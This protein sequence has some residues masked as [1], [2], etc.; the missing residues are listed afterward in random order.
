MDDEQLVIELSFALSDAMEKIEELEVECSRRRQ[1]VKNGDPQ[2]NNMI[3]MKLS[4]RLV[5]LEYITEQQR[6]NVLTTPRLLIQNKQCPVQHPDNKKFYSKLSQLSQFLSMEY[7][8]IMDDQPAILN[9]DRSN[10]YTDDFYRDYGDALIH[11]FMEISPLRNW[12]IDFDWS[13]NTH[14]Q[15]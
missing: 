7:E 9:S 2:Y 14:L 10:I 15:V 1:V 12:D 8:R 13:F 11:C 5:Y 3:R 4:E 6:L